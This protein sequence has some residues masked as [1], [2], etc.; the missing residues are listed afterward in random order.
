MNS[1]PVKRARRNR[2]TSA[3]DH[4]RTI[5]AGRRLAPAGAW[6]RDAVREV[7]RDIAEVKAGR[8]GSLRTYT[9]DELL[10]ELHS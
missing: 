2:A 8:P 7:R 5:S 3:G 9:A 6:L 4:G 1:S 10:K